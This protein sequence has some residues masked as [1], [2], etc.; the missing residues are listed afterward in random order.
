MTAKKRLE[1]Q[2]LL[3]I[4]TVLP[5]CRSLQVSIPQEEYEVASGGDITLTCSFIP[6][7]PDVNMLVLTWEAYPDVVE[8]PMEPVA[9]YFLNNAVDIAPAYEGRAFME[10]DVATQQSTLRLTK[11]TVQDSRHFQC[12]VKIPND[13]E[14]T[15]ASSTSLLVLVPPSKPL[16]RLQG[17]AEYWHNVTLTCTSQEGSPK[18]TYEWKSYSV[19]NVP[20]QFPP[21]TTEKD[22]ALSLFNIS[23][24]TSGFYICVTTNRVGSDKCNFTLAVM[25]GSTDFGATAGIIGGVVA[26]FLLLGIIVFCCYKKRSKKPKNAEGSPK[27]IEFS[28]A[29]EARYRDEEYHGDKKQSEYKDAVP[30]NSH[31]TGTAGHT[32]EEDHHHG[33]DS[34]RYRSEPDQDSQRDQYHGGRERLDQNEYGGRRDRLDDHRDRPDRF[35]D[36]RNRYGGSRDRLEEQNEYRGSRDRLD[37][38]RNRNSRDR[39]DDQRDHY[40]DSRDRLEERNDGRGSRDRLDD[41][42]GR[43]GGSRD[44]LNDAYDR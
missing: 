6:A 19:E 33:S 26:G 44:R 21:K 32:P 41:H 37:D 2:N 15:T 30:Q 4:L 12:S 24:E 25:P 11:L 29:P 38:Q 39:L 40:R 18:P 34:G 36:Q 13:D 1:W 22:G 5:S 23:R 43:Y 42:R 7:K 31:N 10:V 16:C 9:T 3:L 28:D 27:E 14:G 35:D 20:R 17:T 8:D